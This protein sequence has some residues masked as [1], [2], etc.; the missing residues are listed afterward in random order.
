MNWVE[1]VEE[2]LHATSF[3]SVVQEDWDNRE[4]HHPLRIAS[5]ESSE[6]KSGVDSSV[7]ECENKNGKTF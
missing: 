1:Q 6:G 7:K 2:I 4:D 3:L 5:E